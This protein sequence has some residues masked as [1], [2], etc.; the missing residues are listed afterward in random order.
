M[1][2]VENWD[3]W[4]NYEKTMNNSYVHHPVIT[5]YYKEEFFK[6]TIFGKAKPYT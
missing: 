6:D 2:T 5:T 4:E 1:L 3:N